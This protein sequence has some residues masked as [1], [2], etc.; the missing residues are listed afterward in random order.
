MTTGRSRRVRRVVVGAAL[1]AAMVAGALSGTANAAGTLRF[2]MPTGPAT[3]LLPFFVAQDLGWY[4][5]WGLEVEEKVVRGDPNSIRA[6][7]TGDGDVTVVGPNTAMQTIIKGGGLKAISSWQ[8]IT[9]Y[10]II[11]RPEVGTTLAELADKKWAAYSQGGM[12]AEIPKMVLR[13]HGL[14]A[15]DAKILAVGGMSSRMQAVVA[16]KVDVTMVDTFFTEI[17]KQQGLIEI[18][19]IAKEFPGLGYL[20]V[21]TSEK[22]LADP[23]S[24]TAL[25]TFVRGGIEGSRF[26]M[27]EPDRA[28]EV[29]KQRTPDVEMALIQSI[30]RG[31]NDQDVWGPDGGIDPAV[32][33]FSAATY[34]K[35]GAIDRATGYGEVVDSSLVEEVIGEIGKTM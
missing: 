22:N 24:R 31:L 23:A 1:C 20:Y 25:K 27:K 11:T 32:T 26:I 29:M 13:K 19:S 9:D 12:S 6:V 7:I 4:E 5:E 21:V 8:P 16:K 2:I 3:Y 15:D 33:E 14:D 10:R 35:L 30:I 34:H 28:A 18:V 17:G